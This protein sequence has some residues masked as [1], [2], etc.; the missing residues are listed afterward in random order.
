MID[1]ID[2]VGPA[3]RSAL[4]Q[5]KLDVRHRA[6]C[7]GQPLREEEQQRSDELKRPRSYAMQMAGRFVQAVEHD[8]RGHGSCCRGQADSA[9]RKETKI[10]PVLFVCRD[11]LHKDA[12]SICLGDSGTA[13]GASSR[14]W[15]LD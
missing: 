1:M 11:P 3:T 2:Q 10:E 15:I 5:A 13:H 12:L 9:S 14:L 6:E 4:R 7:T 8:I